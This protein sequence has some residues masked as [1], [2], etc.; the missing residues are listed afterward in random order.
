M[1]NKINLL[2]VLL[3]VPFS[4]VC[5]QLSPFIHID[6]FGYSSSAEKVAVLSNPQTGY[7]SNLT[8]SPGSSIQVIDAFTQAV[9]F[10]ASPTMWG[11]GAQD[12][13]SGDQGWWFDF[14]SVQTDGTYYIFDPA[15]NEKS[16]M[17]SINT[18]P[19]QDVLKASFKMFYYNRSNMSKELP[20]AESSW[21]DGTNFLNPLQ[22]ANCRFYLEPNN[23]NKEKDLSGGWFD[24]GDYNKYVN[25]LPNTICPLLSAYEE[26]TALF[27]DD[28]NIPES[29]NGIP[30][31]LDEI[32]YEL[33]WVFKM[34]NVDGSVH[35]KQGS[36]SFGANNSH[37][38]SANVDPRYYGN[39]CTSSSLSVA[40]I[41]S[42]SAK[43]FAA[44][45]ETAYAQTLED[46]AILCFN[47]AKAYIDSNTLETDCDDVTIKASDSDKSIDEQMEWAIRASV[48]LF[49]LTGDVLYR[50]FFDQYYD[51]TEPIV[52]F[53]FSPYLVDLHT[54]LFLYTTLPN[55]DA[56]VRADIL[57]KAQTFLSDNI[58]YSNPSFF[59][60]T[61]NELYRTNV[62]SSMYHWGSNSPIANVSNLCM[63]FKQ[64]NIDANSNA[65]LQRKANETV[66]YF[67]GLNPNGLVYLTNM[68]AYGGD[69]CVDEMYH[70]WFAD[71][72][73]YDNAKTSQFGPAPGY[74]VGG[75]NVSYQPDPSTNIV[76]SPPMNQPEQKSYADFNDD[77]PINSWSISEPAIYYQAAYIRM[78]SQQVNTNAVTNTK[79]VLA[80]TSCMTLYP[81]PTPGFFEIKGILALYRIQII[82]NLGNVFIDYQEK[83]SQLIIDINALPSG[84]FYV[85]I[86]N[87]NNSEVCIEQIIKE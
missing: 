5:A 4:F 31:I 65:I 6:Q 69:R 84:L 13:L 21:A 66:H 71:G 75:A 8:Y 15:N 54:A 86:E 81:N 20:F 52:S 87:L 55:A 39:T 40:A 73:V 3:T 34:T 35:I 58:A 1:R 2:F 24:A 19:Y 48:Y 18:N 46:R 60:F 79:D 30:D 62:P 43:V 70:T 74:L 80:T 64:Y 12:T 28:W 49:E 17:F 83:G 78:M 32:K 57:S 9:V 27:T 38:P 23:L 68:Y 56:T 77:F 85:H 41:F 53:Y 33:D 42:H 37:P 44:E 16:G 72:S 14:T 61:D 7:N 26:N 11:A 82:D 59:K 67:H 50:D 45:G 76:L 29:G 22:D 10:Q 47:Y 25:Y 63:L 36:T 51:T